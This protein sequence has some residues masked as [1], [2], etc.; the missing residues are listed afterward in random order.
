MKRLRLSLSAVLLLLVTPSC[1]TD[2]LLEWASKKPSAY[3]QP[4]EN[5]SVFVRGGG[6]FVALPFAVVWDVLTLPFQLAFGV[7]PYGDEYSP[8][9]FEDEGDS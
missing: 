7:H 9:F 5:R 6:T 1:A 3:R 8:Q 2:H 4:D